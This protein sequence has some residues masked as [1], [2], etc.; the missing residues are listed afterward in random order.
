MGSTRTDIRLDDEDTIAAAQILAW[1]A[2]P[3]RPES[4][5]KALNHWYWTYH[6]KAGRDLPAMPF[7]LEKPGRLQGPMLRLQAE[8]LTAF[9]A[10]V[11]LQW[12][13]FKDAPGPRLG[14]ARHGVTSLAALRVGM[15]DRGNEIAKVWSKRKPVA[16]MCLAAGNAIGRHHRERRW[17]GFGLAGAMLQPSW[18]GEAIEQSEEWAHTVSRLPSAW[19]TFRFHRG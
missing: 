6:R 18:V 19:P 12:T 7:A 4:A 9:R 15:D 5:V 17:R 10:G 16:H 8:C 11:W 13:I 3:H 2:R 1:I 14:G